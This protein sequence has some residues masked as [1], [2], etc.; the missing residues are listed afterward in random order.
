VV[1]VD[2]VVG[3]AV[4]TPGDPLASD[5]EPVSGDDEVHAAIIR[6]TLATA[7]S[8]RGWTPPGLMVEREGGTCAS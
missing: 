4:V 7:T 6:V 8:H 5:E 1:V 3:A 2:P